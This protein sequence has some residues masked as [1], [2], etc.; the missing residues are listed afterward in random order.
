[1]TMTVT[2]KITKTHL[3]I[4][5]AAGLIWLTGFSVF[6]HH[7]SNTKPIQTASKTDAIIVLTGGQDRIHTGL[8]LL[9]QGQANKLFI[10]GVNNTLSLSDLMKI[11]KKDETARN[12]EEKISAKSGHI[13]SH[14]EC[15]TYLGR[16]ATN[17]HENAAE[18][19]SWI[20]TQDKAIK[21]ITLVTAHYH[22]PRASLEF[23]DR[24]PML[25]INHHPVFP[26]KTKP[27][28]IDFW[29]MAF[30]EYHKTIFTWLRTKF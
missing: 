5:I 18:T 10:S 3:A 16:E 14:L 20:K 1:M 17:T 19:S 21:S 24:M 13:Y 25:P 11:W 28:T 7:I 12:E 30:V 4:L 27:Y 2:T 15:C 9:S 8:E 6:T 29:S 26:T 22:M 23:K